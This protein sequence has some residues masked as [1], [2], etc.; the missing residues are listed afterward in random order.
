MVPISSVFGERGPEVSD[1]GY[2]HTL[3]DG[4]MAADTVFT[5]EGNGTE[6]GSA[7]EAF[8]G[9]NST[10]AGKTNTTGAGGPIGYV[11]VD[12]LQ[13]QKNVV[14]NAN[15]SAQAVSPGTGSHTATLQSSTDGTS[16]DDLASVSNNGG[17][18]FK[19]YS[20]QINARYIR[21]K[22]AFGGT[23][24]SSG[25]LYSLRVTKK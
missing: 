21:L 7:S 1:N 10:Y 11:K 25:R 6:V 2:L 18:T 12:M 9:D 8:D 14:V 17:E 15:F 23:D 20:G 13:T 3:T 22:C 24:Q 4:N 19:N 5:F 16:W